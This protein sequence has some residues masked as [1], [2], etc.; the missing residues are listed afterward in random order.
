MA[1]LA[2]AFTTGLTREERAAHDA[3]SALPDLLA[4][5]DCA[6]RCRYANEAHTRWFARDVD[7]MRGIALPELLGTDYARCATHIDAALRGVRQQFTCELTL[8]AGVVVDAVVTFTPDIEDSVVRGCVAHLREIS[9]VT[10]LLDRAHDDAVRTAREPR[11]RSEPLQLLLGD[12]GVGVLVQGAHTEMRACNPAALEMLGLTEDQLLRRSSL[13]GGWRVVREDGTPFDPLDHPV[14]Q[15]IATRVAVRGVVMGVY[16][17]RTDDWAWLLVDAV[18]RFDEQGTVSDVICTFVNITERHH[19][20]QALV[21]SQRRLEQAVKAGQIGLF[22]SDLLTHAITYSP[23]WKQNLGYAPHE[24]ADSLDEWIIRLHPEDRERVVAEVNAYTASEQKESVH[25]FRLLH[26]DGRYRHML[27]RGVKVYDAQGRAVRLVGTAVDITE[28]TDLQ[29]QLQHAQKM[30]SV[31]RLAGGIAH[32]FNNILTVIIAAAELL[33]HRAD[34][35]GSMRTDVQDIKSAGERAALLT[36][37]LLAFGRKQVFSLEHLSVNDVIRS[38][39]R[40]LRRVITENIRLEL[41]LGDDLRCVH[42]DRGQLEQV[43]MN[44][45]VNAL[46]AMPAGGTLRVVTQQVYR[47]ASSEGDGALVPAGHFTRLCISD[48]GVGMDEQTTYKIFEPFFTT[49]GPGHGTGLGLSTVYGIVRQSGG[50][51]TVDSTLGA[52]TRFDVFLPTVATEDAGASEPAD[53][54]D[55]GLATTGVDHRVVNTA[56]PH[57]IP[58]NSVAGA[59]ILVV[60]DDDA[61]RDLLTRCLRSAGY[62]VQGAS[63]GEEALDLLTRGGETIELLLTD[64]MMPGMNG[65]ELSVQARGV[66]PSLK[67]LLTSG[68]VDDATIG[69]ASLDASVPF[70]SK[71]YTPATVLT[72]VRALLREP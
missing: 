52:G 29:Q 53:R 6:Q 36:R 24:I 59:R 71:P 20:E 43:V 34:L 50:V 31:G 27:G 48:S 69:A 55:L 2:Q 70:V 35:Q 14:P 51:I 72:A 57:F 8:A 4:Y 49:K 18:P 39:E 5:W 62:R 65:R 30:E 45:V 17:P 10:R 1:V 54:A 68:Y 19:A 25:A 61:V 60:E 3:L 44:L 46:D 41:A 42:A 47:D 37:Q 38:M 23:Q 22:E 21:E 15:A 12:I 9:E 16:R 63:N 56:P 26:R 40:M 11:A 66:K 64:V 58:A 33:L 7:A 13:D 28:R 32:D 67:V